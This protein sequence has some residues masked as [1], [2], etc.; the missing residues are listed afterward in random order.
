M[1]ETSKAELKRIR[2]L[3]FPPEDTA[4]L[5]VKLKV[6]P[7]KLR[8]L[9]AKLVSTDPKTPK[10]QLDTQQPTS[11]IAL[12]KVIENGIIAFLEDREEKF[13]GIQIQLHTR[14][15]EIGILR[16]QAEELRSESKNSRGLAERR[17]DAKRIAQD[18]AQNLA[19][20]YVKYVAGEKELEEDV[21]RE[22]E[23]L[24]ESLRESNGR[25][26][27]DEELYGVQAEAYALKPRLEASGSLQEMM[28]GQ[29]SELGK[30]KGES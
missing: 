17:E 14:N 27:E 18:S 5:M 1:P 4:K 9:T 2:D 24:E 11:A 25:M 26:R 7:D 21:R 20:K 30:E 12:L 16:S 10:P 6:S 23:R 19:R 29:I 28:Q 8:Q 15:A 3:L 13:E 22:K